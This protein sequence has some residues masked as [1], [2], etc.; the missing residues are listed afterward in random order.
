MT[1]SGT[2]ADIENI[3][4]YCALM[5]I[6]S[7]LHFI[8]FL[9]TQLQSVYRNSKGQ[10]QCWNGV[11]H[12]LANTNIKHNCNLN[13]MLYKQKPHVASRITHTTSVQYVRFRKSQN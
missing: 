11:G 9:I 2:S 13:P 7:V 6:H 8:Y 3:P 1:L 12:F 4:N 5:C 10:L